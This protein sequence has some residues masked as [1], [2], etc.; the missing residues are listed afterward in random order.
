M[1]PYEIIGMFMMGYFG[2]FILMQIFICLVM[3]A[4]SLPDKHKR[5]KRR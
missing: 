2:L 3:L 4:G 5:R 1:N